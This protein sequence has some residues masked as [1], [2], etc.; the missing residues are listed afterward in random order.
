MRNDGKLGNL[1]GKRAGRRFSQA[2]AIVGVMLHGTAATAGAS[3]FV[4]NFE[5][6]D[7]SR[8]YVSDGWNNGD[9]HGCTWSRNNVLVS[10]GVLRLTLD[11][12]ASGDRQYSCGEIQ[13]RSFYGHGTY[14][15]RMRA[16]AEKGTVSAF[17][18]YTGP[19]H[20]NPCDEID[21]EII[22]KSP[23]SLQAN[24]FVD[25]KGGNEKII[26]LG[27]DSSASMNNY[28]FV[29]ASDAL[30]WYIDGRLVHEVTS[31][32]GPLPTTDGKIYM[33]LWNGRGAN[34]ES[35]LGKFMPSSFAMHM[36]IDR[37]S[38]T[39]PGAP[40]QF[41]ESIVC[42]M[43]TEPV[44]PPPPAETSPEPIRSKP[45]NNRGGRKK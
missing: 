45:G 41:P 15:V 11:T 34:M 9:W 18:T 20:K 12:Q 14:E 40:C 39:A 8:W 31:A 4:E 13:T 26:S 1:V 22:G 16:L 30:R 5:F 7:T 28:A 17:F 38:Y 23:G 27:F 3:S 37:V 2:A 10:G 43:G 44:S 35:W 19:V 36:E 21:I 32:S 25:C 42:A 6:L 24:Y 29:W 33:S